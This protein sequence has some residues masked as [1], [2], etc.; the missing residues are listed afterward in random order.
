MPKV[1][2]LKFKCW[3]AEIWLVE[4]LFRYKYP[5]LL[6]DLFRR[7]ISKDEFDVTFKVLKIYI[8][9]VNNNSAPHKSNMSNLIKI[10]SQINPSLELIIGLNPNQ[11]FNNFRIYNI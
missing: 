8:L 5:F 7:K 4:D 11:F 1:K 2:I 6:P 10:L 9:L 3:M